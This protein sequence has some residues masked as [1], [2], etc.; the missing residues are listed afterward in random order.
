MLRRN[1][2][3]WLASIGPIRLWAQ[4]SAFPGDQG[5]ALRALAAVVLPSELGPRNLESTVAAFERWVRQYRPGAEMDH[6]Y[7]VTRLRSKPP[8]PAP[9]YLEQLR[10]LRLTGDEPSDRAT[11]ETALEAAQIAAL[12][13]SP[14]GKHVATDLM[15]FFFHSSEANDLCYRAQIGRDLCR[16]L[17]GSDREPK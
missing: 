3:R 15:A 12:P 17:A 5:P 13:R 11:V 1:L 9:A 6:G 10:A 8:S 14:D 2:L 7:G 16:G 4:S